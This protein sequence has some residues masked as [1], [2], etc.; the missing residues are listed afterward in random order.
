VSDDRRGDQA[1]AS[2]FLQACRGEIPSRRP[3]WLMRQAGRILAPYRRLKEKTGSI[4]TLFRTPDLAAEITLMPVEM[5]GVDAAILFADILTPID[6]MGCPVAFQPGPVMTPVR[7]RGDVEALRIIDSETDLAYVAQTISLILPALPADVP[8]IGF[9]GSPF[10]L[11]AYLAE[12]GTSKDFTQFRRMFRSDPD[13]AHLLLSKLTDVAIDYLSMQVRAGVQAVQ[14]FDTWI[15]LLSATDFRQLALPYLRRIFDALEPLGVPRIY[16]GNG[17]GHFLTQLADTGADVLSLDWRT[18]I[19]AAFKL[20]S[21]PT[22]PLQGNLD[23]CAL[24]GSREQVES[25]T[26]SLLEVTQGRPHIFNLGHG[27]QPD[28]PYDNV[29]ALVDTVHAHPSNPRQTE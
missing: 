17:A 23:P 11:A 14:I 28:T 22:I 8:L 3:V 13:T 19:G 26:R 27:V 1:A 2:P 15:G 25:A 7:T 5:L 6:P 24:F 18:D 21:E 10:T 20:F 4:L 9:A 16:F 12:G 29:K